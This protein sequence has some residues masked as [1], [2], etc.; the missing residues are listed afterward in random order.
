MDIHADIHVRPLRR[1]EGAV[2]DTV[3]AGLS[4]QSR[5][6][7]FHS[8][9][10]QLAAPVRRAL[11]AVDGRDHVALVAMARGEPVGIAR[12]IRDRLRPDEAEVAFEVVD[13][14]QRRGVGRLL[15]TALAERAERHRRQAGAR[16]RAAG[17]HR[18]LRCCCGRCS[19]CASPAA[20]GT[21]PNWSASRGRPATRTGRPEMTSTPFLERSVVAAA[22]RDTVPVAASIAPLALVIGA[23]AA[24][25]GVPV[26]ADMAGAAF[27]F[28]GAAHLAVLT[29]LGAGALTALSAAA[30]INVR[31]LLYSASIEPRF[32]RQPRWFRWLGP[33]L[34]IDQTYLMVTARDDLAEPARFRRYWSCAGGLLIGCWVATVALGSVLGPLLPA[35]VPL[36]A[37][38]VAVLVG[39]LAPR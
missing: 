15:L 28:A 29:T 35:G 16:P 19:R 20:T 17:E 27:I 30:L 7:R 9:I 1:D 22:V 24:R 18:G 31:L 39:M 33:A 13:A 11:L 36:D 34:L 25:S 8:P 10:P 14:W 6:L 4:P 2:L 21:R 23:T 38:A 3:F 26:P 5:Y 37:A 32:R 12:L